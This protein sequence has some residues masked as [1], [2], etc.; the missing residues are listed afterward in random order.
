VKVKP[1]VF[2]IPLQG[3]TGI[4]APQNRHKL[5]FDLRS[6]EGRTNGLPAI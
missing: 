1:L 3:E 4:R 2:S 6:N 5:P